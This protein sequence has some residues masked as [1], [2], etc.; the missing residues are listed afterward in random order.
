MK[1][2]LANR[3]HR[4]RDPQLR[5]LLASIDIR[6]PSPEPNRKEPSDDESSGTD[7]EDEDGSESDVEEP[8]VEGPIDKDKAMEETEGVISS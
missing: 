8:A 6:W 4:P 5:S 1:N 2:R 7:T 3:P